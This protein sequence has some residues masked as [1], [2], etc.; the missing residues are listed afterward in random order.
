MNY[1]DIIPYTVPVL[2][3]IGYWYFLYKRGQKPVKNSFRENEAHTPLERTIELEVFISPEEFE[4]ANAQIL[5]T[6]KWIWLYPVAFFMILLNAF[7]GTQMSFNYVALLPL[8]IVVLSLVYS[9]KFGTKN[10]YNRTEFLKHKV[11]YTFNAED[12]SLS[13]EVLSHNGKWTTIHG[14]KILKDY[15][16]VFTSA[17]QAFFLPNTS[18]K[19]LE[20]YASFT[21]F[22]QANFSKV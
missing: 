13:S 18:F 2:A 1:L 5:K 4:K 6:N 3:L 9:V 15:V 8:L 11:K 12:Y 21:S 10:T 19:S 17:S 14:Y 7:T 20:D 22:L 16:L